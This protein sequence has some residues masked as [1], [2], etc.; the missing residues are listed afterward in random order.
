MPKNYGAKLEAVCTI[1]HPRRKSW[2]GNRLPSK[3]CGGG[4]KVRRVTYISIWGLKRETYDLLNKLCWVK[5]LQYKVN[6]FKVT[7]KQ[8]STESGGSANFDVVR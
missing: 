3:V 5:G 4:T 1:T 8:V 2:Y 7:L 6:G